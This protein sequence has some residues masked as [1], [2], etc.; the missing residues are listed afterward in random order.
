ME[1]PAI[2]TN[3]IPNLNVSQNSANTVG[4]PLKQNLHA[5]SNTP[6]NIL[7][8]SITLSKGELA[9]NL[10]KVNDG[11]MITS[12]V[13]KGLQKQSDILRDIKDDL[14]KK[15]QDF[16]ID[17]DKT[18]L[19][20]DVMNQ[21]QKFNEITQN[22]KYN[23]QNLLDSSS[24]N[25]I[26]INTMTQTIELNVPS[27][28]EIGN[29]ISSYLSRTDLSSQ[30]LNAIINKIDESLEKM[31][32]FKD[33]FTQTQRLL[34]ENAK[35]TIAEQSRESIEKAEIQNRNYGVEAAEF[36]KA[37]VNAVAGHL[38]AS[39]ANIPQSHG[40]RLLY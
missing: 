20:N 25:N 37:N 29:D 13:D 3:N 10:K 5:P 9:Q 36:S 8:S 2:N 23:E 18:E 27:T 30:N 22:L 33:E 11:V 17:V 28:Q 14:T 4:A 15:L 19:K 1:T 38:V 40:M 24:N 39:Q 31:N 6:S 21:L 34:V 35:N 7:Q 32:K 26:E 12:L 16:N